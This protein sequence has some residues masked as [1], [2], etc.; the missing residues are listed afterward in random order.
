MKACSRAPRGFKLASMSS[1]AGARAYRGTNQWILVVSIARI[2]LFANFMTVAGTIPLLKQEWNLTSTGAGA[3]VTS[4]TMCYS[5]SLFIF[6]WLADH[7]GAKRSVMI[8]AV[9][10][11]SAA[12]LFGFFARD[13]TS[14]FVLY[15]L[16]GLCHGGIYTPVIMV[17]SD[18]VEPNRLG[19]AMGYLI[20]STSLGYAGSLMATAAGMWIGGWKAAFIAGGVLPMFGAA[21]LLVALWPIENRIHAKTRA[22]AKLS[23]VRKNRDG[24]LLIGTYVAHTWEL[25]GMWAWLPAFLS[26]NLVLSGAG[27]VAATVTGASVSAI[28]H[29]FGSAASVS[30]GRISDRVGRRPVIVAMAAASAALS[31]VI[32]W[33]VAWP[34]VI[35]AGIGIAYAMLCLGDSPV[36]TT[37]ISERVDP[38]IL[39]RVLAIRGLMGFGAGAISPLVLGAVLDA[40]K[41]AALSQPAQW[42]LA[43]AVLGIGGI[44]AAGCARALPRLKKS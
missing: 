13:W 17:F 41:A 12:L 10:S 21:I 11:A 30:T 18:E 29:L 3:I 14:A 23:E 40:T 24:L 33:L 31:F 37:A 36:M 22:P 44:A 8:S 27:V 9:A 43:F 32:G 26:I 25:L 15:G 42:G 6:A 5:A 38:V 19:T 35:V 16:V 7:I 20:G 34:P 28:M 4:F 1:I 39:G 2:L